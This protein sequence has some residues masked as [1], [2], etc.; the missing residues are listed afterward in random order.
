MAAEGRCQ[1]GAG[2][3]VGAD[4]E[5]QSRDRRVRMAARDDIERLQQRHA[6]LEHRGELAGEHA[7]IF[8]A[9]AAGAGGGLFLQR[10]DGDALPA[11]LQ[12]GRWCI[13]CAQL[14]LHHA[15]GAV[16]AFPEVDV[17]GGFFCFQRG[18]GHGRRA[19]GRWRISGEAADFRR[20]GGFSE[21]RRISPAALSALRQKKHS[22]NTVG[23]IEP[24]AKSAIIGQ[25]S[26]S[27]IIGQRS[28]SAITDPRSKS[29]HSA[30]SRPPRT[31][32]ITCSCTPKSPPDSSTPASPSATPTPASSS[33]LRA[34][35]APRSRAPSPARG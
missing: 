6:G 19:P 34:A 9:D 26:K 21:R 16:R 8:F 10:G 2:F 31:A 4:V 15:A 18:L 32:A 7:E 17:V 14:A 28:K 1:A 20:G 12:A 27:A 23:R 11:Q 13:R 5:Q 35:T 22:D 25:R 30:N 33:P 24:Q 29:A 3:D